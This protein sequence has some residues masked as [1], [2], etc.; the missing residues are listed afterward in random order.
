M[1]YIDHMAPRTFTTM[2][3]LVE[4]WKGKPA[5]AIKAEVKA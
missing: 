1:L 5:A 4:F 2:D 3:N